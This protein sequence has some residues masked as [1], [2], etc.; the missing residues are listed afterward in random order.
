MILSARIVHAIPSTCVQLA[1]T[2]YG[3][4]YFLYVLKEK[5][6]L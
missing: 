1:A 3:L 6:E 5:N 4:E 2:N